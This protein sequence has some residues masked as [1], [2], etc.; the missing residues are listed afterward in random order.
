MKG[1]IFLLMGL[2]TLVFS[3]QTG[4]GLE[5]VTAEPEAVESV[6]VSIAPAVEEAPPPVVPAP[7]AAVEDPVVEEPVIEVVVEPEPI[8]ELEPI[9]EVEAIAEAE[10]E[11]EG[12]DPHSIPQEVFD[13][14]KTDVQELINSLNG[15]VR[16][17]NYDGWITYLS[18]GYMALLSSPEYLRE[19]SGST[20]L[21]TQKIVLT[22]LRDYFIHVVVPSRANVRVDDIEFVSPTRVR[23]FS[24]SARGQRLR[25]Y[26]LE[27]TGNSWK[28][29]N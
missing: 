22:G 23:A 24:V 8:V 10:P 18:Q 4:P 20:R 14:T 25:L 16:S 27:K 13:S 3:C 1:S 29:I 11:E 12:F 9:V 2:L 19:A 26:D 21:S 15:I 5:S 7:A 17:R 6:P 28:I